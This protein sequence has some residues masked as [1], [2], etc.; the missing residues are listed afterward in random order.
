MAKH[1]R[2][3][4]LDRCVGCYQCV[5]ACARLT[6]KVL[7][8]DRASIKVKTVGGYGKSGFAVVV[9]RGCLQPPCVPVCPIEDAI[10]KRTNGGGVLVNRSICDANKCRHECVTACPIPGALH[11]DED[12]NFAIVCRQCGLCTTFCPTEVLIM[13]EPTRYF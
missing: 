3:E 12:L 2:I 13:K 5:L 8:I 1:L 9:C 7:S 4:Y 11:I 10:R 6:E